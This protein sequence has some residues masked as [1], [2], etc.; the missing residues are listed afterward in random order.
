M[1]YL[2]AI[3]GVHVGCAALTLCG[4][5]M[6]GVW[7]MRDSPMRRRRWVRVVPHVV[8]TVLLVSAVVLAVGIH[9]YPVR[10]AWLT[11][12]VV[13]LVG[14]IGFGMV[15]LRYGRSR[16]VRVGAWVVAISVFFYVV[17]VAVSRSPFPGMG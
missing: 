12:K 17:A 6:R 14:Y 4:F 9:Q 7:M 10:D 11:A 13:G 16:R 15:A 5:V 8:D 2:G 1:L 3:K